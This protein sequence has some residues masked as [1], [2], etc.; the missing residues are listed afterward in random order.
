M[1]VA[2]SAG[3]TF[4]SIE[5]AKQLTRLGVDY[6]LY[7]GASVPREIPRSR[8][9]SYRAVSLLGLALRKIAL[10]EKLN[11]KITALAD[12]AFDKLVA[13]NISAD[14]DRFHGF[15]VYSLYTMRKLE[16]ANVPCI[17]DR[18]SA[19]PQ[20]YD[21]IVGKEYAELGRRYAATDQASVKK[22]DAEYS[23]ANAVLSPSSYVTDSLVKIG[24]ERKKIVQ[25]P[26]GAPRAIT[27][28]PK[29]DKF[30]VLFIGGTGIAK[31]LHYLAQAFQQMNAADSELLVVG[32][33]EDVCP[34]T[35]A[36]KNARFE[37]KLQGEALKKAFLSSSVLVLPSLSD[38]W[39]MVVTEAMAH[40]LPVIVSE[41]TGA[42]DAVENGKNG[43][44][45]P[46]KSAEAIR[47]KLE[48]L[49]NSPDKA[50]KMGQNAKKTAGGYSWNKYGEKLIAA[51]QK[52][53]A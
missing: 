7:S 39:G 2:L 24:V 40:G 38:G 48:F 47:D 46:I 15:S 32:K 41:N 8:V 36:G 18:G 50:A 28:S 25:L 31:G 6:T 10:S 27:E 43:F 44:I 52:L 21:E 22:Q 3:G 19:P 11:R 35:S 49:H 53:E 13:R 23:E 9:H 12:D 4:H 16:K 29:P 30:R 20:Q 34:I 45:I 42:K 33:I 51:Y 5:I 17:V 14:I 26:Y 1:R 37:K